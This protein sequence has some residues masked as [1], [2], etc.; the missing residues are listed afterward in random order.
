MKNIHKKS[1][2]NETKF[3]VREDARELIEVVED[4]RNNDESLEDHCNNEES[5]DQNLPAT[6]YATARNRASSR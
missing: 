2:R 1:K 6:R 3:S 4:H 5:S